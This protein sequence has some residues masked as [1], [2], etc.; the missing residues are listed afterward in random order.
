VFAELLRSKLAGV[1]ELTN[2]QM[3]Q[4]RLHYELL[5][6]WNRVLNLTAVRTIEEAVERHYCESVFLAAHLPEDRVTVADLGSGAGFPGI[7]VAIVRP[8]CSVALIESHQKKAVFLREAS[9]KLANVRVLPLRAD[10]VEDRFDWVVSRAVKYRDV[11]QA[12]KRLASNAEILTGEVRQSELPGFD[13][14]EP[15]RLPW[16]QHK[17]LWIGRS[18]VSRGTSCT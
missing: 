6:R 4:L 3:E 14:Q 18:S 17:L 7:V 1:C 16:G 11:A 5:T 12:L 13:W 10:D 8:Q 9:R 2:G 15:I